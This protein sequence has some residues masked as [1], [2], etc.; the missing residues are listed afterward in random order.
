[1]RGYWSGFLIIVCAL[2]GLGAAYGQTASSTYTMHYR[3]D[4]A[5]RVVGSIHSDPDGGAY[6][7]YP[8]T[9]TTYDSRGRVIREES[10]ELSSW[11]APD[12]APSAWPGFTVY[13]T[14][15]TEYDDLGRPVKSY[16]LD[17]TTR[18]TQAETSYDGFG[19]TECSVQ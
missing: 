10:G 8:A 18:L 14:V 2:L 5:R 19:R 11:Q 16:V 7:K 3:Y 17:G 12:I 9:R 15:E 4:D 1:M 13:K 6:L